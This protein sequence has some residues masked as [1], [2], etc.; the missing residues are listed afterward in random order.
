M[1]GGV[2]PEEGAGEAVDEEQGKDGAVEKG[3]AVVGFNEP[4]VVNDTAKGADINESMEQLPAL[5][6]EA[7][8]PIFCGSERERNQENKTEKTDG[9]EGTLVDILPHA[10]KV[11]GL[12]GTEIGEEVEAG[13]EEG[14]KAEHTS[15]TNEIGEGEKLAQ[16]CN[17]ESDEQEAESPITGEVLDEF[18]GIGGELAVIGTQ[19]EEPKRG[20][21]GEK[22]ERLG[23]LAEEQLAEKEH[24]SNIVS[25]PCR[26]KG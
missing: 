16:G 11:E 2:R 24:V 25:G 15:E 20:K 6:T 5:A 19:G 23:P 17:G 10:A 26:C 1:F 18:D 9:D 13:I 22:N 7:T 12:I 14:E 21:T 3:Q 4:I 8:D